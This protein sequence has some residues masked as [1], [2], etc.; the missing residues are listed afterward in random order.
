MGLPLTGVRVVEVATHVFVPMSGSVLTEWGAEVIKIEHPETGDPYRGLVTAGLHKLHRGVDASFQSA[1]RGKQSV[2]IDLKQAD[3]RRV[4]GRLVNDADVFV[5]NLTA[6]ARR[7]L[8]IEVTDVRADN[9]DVIYVRGTAFGARGPEAARG[10]YDA[11]AYWA[12][13]GMQFV[14]TGQDAAWPATPRP[15]FGDV[16]GGLTIA[17]A[18]GVAL[19]RRAATGEPSVIDASLLASGMWQLQADIMHASLGDTPT[20]RALPDRYEAWNPLMLPYRTKDGRFIVLMMLTPDPNWPNLC[21]TLGQPEMA[22]DPRFVDMA[23]RHTNARACVEWLEGIFAE[24]T[25]DEWRVIFADFEGEWAAVQGPHEMVADPQV[26]ANGYVAG[27]DAGN[28]VVIPVVTAPVQ[29][30]EEPGHPIRAPEHGE[31]TES[32][33]LASGLSWDELDDLKERGVIL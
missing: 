18:I 22:A 16:V 12:R 1:N 30:D 4:L 33:L 21:E 2:A 15:A 19:Y 14:F 17:G 13:S 32:C 20:A 29:F 5:T 3:G 23:V 24:H 7:R 28:D 31:H 9:P 27:L 26:Q 25:F 10:G 8:A 11:G 6:D